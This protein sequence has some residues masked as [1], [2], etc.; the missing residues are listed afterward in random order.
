MESSMSMNESEKQ[1]YHE[2]CEIDLDEI[3][4]SCNKI[5]GLTFEQKRMMFN[6][7][8]DGKWLLDS[9]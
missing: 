6:Y 1:C 2:Y 8:K 7:I 5:H 9:Y 4:S 3:E